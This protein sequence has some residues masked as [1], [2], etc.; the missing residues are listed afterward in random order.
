LYRPRLGRLGL[1]SAL[2]YAYSYVVF[3]GTVV[4]AMVNHTKDYQTL[5]DHSGTL[6]TAH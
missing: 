6:M 3:T 1:V 4:Y 2:A 5:N